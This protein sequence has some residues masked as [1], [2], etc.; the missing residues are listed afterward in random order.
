MKKT[1]IQPAATTITFNIESDV[2]TLLVGSKITGV[3]TTQSDDWSNQKGWDSA[4]WSGV[5]DED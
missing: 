3:S 5:D 2:A 1:Y 4:S